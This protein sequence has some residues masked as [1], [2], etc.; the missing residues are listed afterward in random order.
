M[1]LD[2]K[3]KIPR[4]GKP[5]DSD[6]KQ[7]FAYNLHWGAR[8]SMLIYP[9]AHSAQSGQ[10][11]DFAHSLALPRKYKHSYAMCFIDLF[12]ENQKLR[13]DIGHQIAKHIFAD[14]HDE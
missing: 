1:V 6:L 8:R 14:F 5:E 12:D 2:T 4:D 10:C 9:R 11:G 3:W 13:K 7:M